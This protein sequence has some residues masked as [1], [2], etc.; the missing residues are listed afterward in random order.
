MKN[1]LSAIKAKKFDKKKFEALSKKVKKIFLDEE[2]VYIKKHG[3]N[4]SSRIFVDY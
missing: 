1:E 3:D 2:R 4:P